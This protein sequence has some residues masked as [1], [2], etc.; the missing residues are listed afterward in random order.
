MRRLCV[1]PES[2]GTSLSGVA[3]ACGLTMLLTMPSAYRWYLARVGGVDLGGHVLRLDEDNVL[4]DS[5]GLDVGFVSRLG[6]AE[7]R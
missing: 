4:V 3:R 2:R 7:P 5:A 6:A 1:F